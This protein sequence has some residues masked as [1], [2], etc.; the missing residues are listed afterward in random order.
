MDRA[1]DYG[2][3][4]CRFESCRSHHFDHQRQDEKFIPLFSETAEPKRCVVQLKR[5]ILPESLKRKEMSKVCQLTG[6]RPV[7]GNTV[8]HSN[9]KIKR[10]FLPN[11]QT[12]RFYV[13]E[14][15]V[16]VTLKVSAAAMRSIDK[17]GVYEFVQKMERKGINTGVKF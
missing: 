16:W 5:E 9:R 3:E 17:M 7:A 13:P 12:K 4:G 11:L 6:K 14:K 10:R 2:S 1:S 15:D 8:S